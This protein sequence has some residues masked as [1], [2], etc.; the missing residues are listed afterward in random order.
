MNSGLYQKGG[1]TVQPIISIGTQDFEFLRENN[2]FFIDK[3]GF[4]KEWWENGDAVTL[5]TRPRRFGKTLNISMLKAFFPI[6]IKVE[7]IY[8]KVF[9]SGK[10]KNTV[11]CR[12]AIL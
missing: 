6:N 11:I 3:T 2:Y 8:L 1:W 7:A 12:G 5:I 9:L 10:K 4:I